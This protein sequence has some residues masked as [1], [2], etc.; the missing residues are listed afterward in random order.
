MQNAHILSFHWH[1]LLL[2][3]WRVGQDHQRAYEAEA[4]AHE[5]AEPFA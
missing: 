4:A 1:W 5:T 2:L 3:G